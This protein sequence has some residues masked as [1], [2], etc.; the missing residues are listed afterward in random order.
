MCYFNVSKPA[1]SSLI[2]LSRWD[3]TRMATQKR[4]CVENQCSRSEEN[5]SKLKWKSC[6]Q[7]YGILSRE[8]VCLKQFCYWIK[9]KELTISLVYC[10][11]TVLKYTQNLHQ[12][13]NR[14]NVPLLKHP[15]RFQMLR[16]HMGVWFVYRHTKITNTRA[17]IIII[18]IW[19]R[20][21]WWEQRGHKSFAK[22]NVLQTLMNS[23]WC[24]RELCWGG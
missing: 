1:S 14:V 24:R 15:S 9:S 11:N 12:T 22:S 10:V 13:W 3:F 19:L 23:C 17:I 7:Q 4:L 8:S 2:R 18:P 20:W 6:M 21:W 16:N 5:L